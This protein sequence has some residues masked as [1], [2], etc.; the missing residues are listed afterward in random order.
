[1]WRDNQDS[2]RFR[3]ET[4]SRHFLAILVELHVKHVRHPPYQAYCKGKIEAA[5]KIIKNQF[6]REA[7]V[8][9][10]RTI[11]ELNSAF[12]AW[13]DLEYNPRVLAA[14][15]QSPDVRFR[16]GLPTDHRRV[17]DL[18]S[19]NALFLWRER[20]TVSK[21]GRIKLHGNQYPVTGVPHGTVVEVRF[22]PYD[23]TQLA[24]YDAQGVLIET[25]SASKQVTAQVP[26]VPEESRAKPAQV[27]TAAR[28]YFTRL[29]EQHHDVLRDRTQTSFTRFQSTDDDDNKEHRNADA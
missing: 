13:M 10:F 14:T 20:R 22:D 4:V 11:D 23:L 29:R 6:Q 7:Q 19:F 2:N 5:D 17:T 24:I 26:T 1:M 12:W 18:D 9:G 16:D 3:N 21:Y 8:A 27:S 28:A 25:T 15:G